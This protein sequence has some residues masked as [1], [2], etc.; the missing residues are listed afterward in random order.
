MPPPTSKNLMI[1][2]VLNFFL[3]LLIVGEAEFT[4]YA[5]A[6]PPLPSP[7]SRV[8][9]WSPANNRIQFVYDAY[10]AETRSGSPENPISCARAPPFPTTV[11]GR[12]GR[13]ERRKPERRAEENSENIFNIK[14]GPSDV[15]SLI[16][17]RK[18]HLAITS[19]YISGH[20]PETRV[21]TTISVLVAFILTLVVVRNS[22]NFLFSR[23][24]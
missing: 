8:L 12:G 7:P 9:H 15:F 16:F 17:Q 4:V 19:D 2:I 21:F 11:G 1:T 13:E 5:N 10:N 23:R 20:L 24:S 3:F 14:R 22:V 18:S 6:R